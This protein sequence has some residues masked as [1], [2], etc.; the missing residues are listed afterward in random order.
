MIPLALTLALFGT[1]DARPRKAEAPPPAATPEAAPAP[2]APPGTPP[3]LPPPPVPRAL[4]DT[5]AR[6]DAAFSG[7]DLAALESICTP[8]YWSAPH[9]GGTRLAEQA[10]KGAHF[11]AGQTSIAPGRAVIVSDFV[12]DEQVRDRVWTYWV[13]VEGAWRLDG[14]DESPAHAAAFLEGRIGGWL[15]DAELVDDPELRRIGGEL[16]AAAG[17]GSVDGATWKPG[18]GWERYLEQLHAGGSPTVART[19]AHAGLGRGLVCITFADHGPL[20]V[21]LGKATGVWRV[22]GMGFGYKTCT[23]GIRDLFS[24][25]G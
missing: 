19:W 5:H 10:G 7:G 21:R 24:A 18:Q 11:R 22:D 12:R 23:I 14:V 3:G 1:A 2:A 13:D 20:K 25:D 9:D 15:D 16:L 6:L 8:G 17:G 4:M